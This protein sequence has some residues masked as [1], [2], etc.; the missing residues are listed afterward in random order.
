MTDWHTLVSCAGPSAGHH[1]H[2]W[3]VTREACRNGAQTAPKPSAQACKL[4]CSAE[5]LTK[6]ADQEHL[7]SG[8]MRLS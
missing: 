4:L 3:S 7:N 8:F 6:V 5:G 1:M 2:V